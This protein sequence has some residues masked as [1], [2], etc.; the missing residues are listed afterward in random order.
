MSISRIL[1]P[2]E[3]SPNCLEA[4]EMAAVWAEK[5]GAT[6]DIVH[7]WDHP[8]FVPEDV[9]VHHGG[10][11]RASLKSLIE[12]AAQDEMTQFLSRAQLPA[13]V[14]THSHLATGEPARAILDL[15]AKRQ[16]D[17][18]VLSTHARTGFRHFLMG[19][20]AE[21]VVRLAPVPVLTVPPRNRSSA[22]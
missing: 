10:H 16:V 22:T 3:Y 1:V 7:V 4:L 11:G 13:T 12:R 19:S 8:N 5:L 6:L 21:K 17:L 18:V 15:I 14:Q 2:V 9:T 20:V